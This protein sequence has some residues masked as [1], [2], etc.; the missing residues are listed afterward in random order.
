[1]LIFL[2]L[3]HLRPKK[4]QSPMDSRNGVFQYFP[5]GKYSISVKNH[6]ND[7][8]GNHIGDDTYSGDDHSQANW[9]V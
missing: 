1:M 5:F 2:H 6:D 3:K 9:V 7:Q 8:G 4:K